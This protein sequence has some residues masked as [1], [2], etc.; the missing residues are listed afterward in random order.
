M[1]HVWEHSK[2]KNTRLLLLLAIADNANDNGFAWPSQATL[3]KKTRMT[4]RNVQLLSEKLEDAGELIIYNR[5][6]ETDDQQHYSN[7]YQIPLPGDHALPAELRGVFKRHVG[8]GSVENFTRG[9]ENANT[10]VAKTTTSEPSL[11]PSSLEPPEKEKELVSGET[12]IPTADNSSF[13]DTHANRVDVTKTALQFGDDSYPLVAKYAQFLS[14][15]VKE[16]DTRGHS[17]GEWYAYQ[18]SRGMTALE[19]RAF[20]LWLADEYEGEP[21]RK[22][23]ALLDYAGRFRA[24]SDHALYMRRAGRGSAPPAPEPTE[25]AAL[26]GETEQADVLATLAALVEKVST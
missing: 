17:N 21:L 16:K 24:D 10:T 1:S 14:G 3:A 26:V 19:I 23:A 22:P 20:G 9:S 13:E 11:E 7:V 2:Q 8:R 15:T 25:P 6:S 4:K 18:L 5:V 12:D